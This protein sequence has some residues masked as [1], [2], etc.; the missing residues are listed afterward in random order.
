MKN[1]NNKIKPNNM[2]KIKYK[3]LQYGGEKYN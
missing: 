3:M 1:N 2:R